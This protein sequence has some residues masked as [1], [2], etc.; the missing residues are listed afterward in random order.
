MKI[1]YRFARSNARYC[2]N[3]AISESPV[4]PVFKDCPEASQMTRG[5][6]VLWSLQMRRLN[7]LGI[8]G[9]QTKMVHSISLKYGSKDMA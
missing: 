4:Y 7:T 8:S 3:K 2:W 9:E 5:L 6:F 1:L